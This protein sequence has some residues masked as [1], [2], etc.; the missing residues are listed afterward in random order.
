MALYPNSNRQLITGPALQTEGLN[1][2]KSEMVGKWADTYPDR[3]SAER[4]IRRP[5]N[6]QKS[7]IPH[8]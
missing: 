2:L 8:P 4:P 7:I 5:V 1:C 3:F 6:R